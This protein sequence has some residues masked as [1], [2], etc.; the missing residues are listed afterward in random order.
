MTKASS[1]V[2]AYMIFLEA[3]QRVLDEGIPVEV[4]ENEERATEIARCIEATLDLVDEQ[5][6][7]S[8]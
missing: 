7:V 4:F 8:R 5:Q 6:E 1:Q 3:A 2:I